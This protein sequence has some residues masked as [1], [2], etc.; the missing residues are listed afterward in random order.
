MS[1]RSIYRLQRYENLFVL[2]AVVIGET[3][4]PR[5]LRLLVDTGSSFT[6]L[7]A[8]ILGEIGCQSDPATRRISIMAAGGVIQAPT[9]RVPIFN[10]LGQQVENFSAISLDLPFNSLVNGLLGMD[11]L[12]RC[13][14][15][16][17][18]KKSEIK[19]QPISE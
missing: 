10:C 6:V 13:S 12:D 17:D 5:V 4:D 14:T 15:V 18:I 16:I 8:T 9:L 2:R 11:F 3:G 19:V 1:A 7:S